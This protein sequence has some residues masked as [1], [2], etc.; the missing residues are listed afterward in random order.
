MACTGTSSIHSRQS[1]LSETV[2]SP[3]LLVSGPSLTHKKTTAVDPS[4]YSDPAD[5]MARC[6][7]RV[8]PH[9]GL[10][11]CP[12]DHRPLI[13]GHRRSARRLPLRK[14]VTRWL[15]LE[16]LIHSLS[17][18]IF[19][20]RLR[21]R[22]APLRPSRT[23][24]HSLSVLSWHREGILGC[25]GYSAV[26]YGGVALGGILASPKPRTGSRWCVV[27]LGLASASVALWLCAWG[28]EEFGGMR[29][30]RR[31]VNAPYVV[32]TLAVSTMPLLR[33][34]SPDGW[35]LPFGCL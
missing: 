8:P 15:P 23:F 11:G 18:A 10:R 4:L 5:G 35:Q 9:R 3:P 25:V 28:M 7:M 20:S 6:S 16:W 19:F 30:S 26:F 2:A 24:V 33:Q 17:H 22:V 34:S 14:Q 12:P 29:V 31:L 13:L 21:P 32:W 27:A 1:A